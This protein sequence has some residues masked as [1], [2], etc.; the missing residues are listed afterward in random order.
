MQFLKL[1]RRLNATSLL[2]NVSIF[3]LVN[4]FF[5]YENK[6][7]ILF[8]HMFTPEVLKNQKKGVPV[9]P[10]EAA[11]GKQGCGAPW[12]STHS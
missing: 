6:A 4:C 11:M 5:S 3:F 2:R 8:V 1:S 7:L 9:D 10:G 12:L